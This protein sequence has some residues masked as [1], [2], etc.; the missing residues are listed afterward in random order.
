MKFTTFAAAAALAS[1]FTVSAAS[2]AAPVLMAEAFDGSA[3]TG[4][5]IPLTIITNN[6]GIYSA[7]GSDANFLNVQVSG[8]GIPLNTG[9]G[10]T[11]LDAIA[12]TAATLTIVL[13]Q[14]G[15][16]ALQANQPF[17]ETFTANALL[18]PAT[19][20]FTYSDFVSKTN[21][22]FDLNP[23]DLV[24][25][26]ATL[27]ETANDGSLKA[28]G[29]ATGLTV[30]G[31]FSETE[32]INIT[33]STGSSGSVSASSQMLPTAVPEPMSLAL[34]GSGLLGVSVLV[35][36]PKSGNAQA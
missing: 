28:P 32:E 20:T 34:L 24:T 36:R 25:P 23:A 9:L 5:A 15:I 29:T 19:A 14:T 7:S 18:Y 8:N 10:L 16:T 6:N 26:V 31:L 12:T 3:A 33:F 22:A 17:A 35:R 30:G 27:V 21:M 4:T 1:A 11:T 13:T 2:H